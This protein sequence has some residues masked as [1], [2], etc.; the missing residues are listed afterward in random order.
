MGEEGRLGGGCGVLFFCWLGVFWPLS[1][2]S[3]CTAYRT[4]HLLSPMLPGRSPSKPIHMAS[5]CMCGVVP[6]AVR[7]GGLGLGAD[8]PAVGSFSQGT[9]TKKATWLPPTHDSLLHLP[10]ALPT[11]FPDLYS[12]V[13][14]C[15]VG[16]GWER[17]QGVWQCSSACAQRFVGVWVYGRAQTFS[18]FFSFSRGVFKKRMRWGYPP[19][20]YPRPPEVTLPPT[21][22]ATA[23]PLPLPTSHCLTVCVCSEETG[24]SVVV[25]FVP[26]ASPMCPLV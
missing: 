24:W 23:L 7:L 6:A 3:A 2:L 16:E 18:L 4:R 9:T 17:E 5:V 1:S 8:W 22:F 15:G 21:P 25:P 26:F 13:Q 14:A 11:P 12:L 10:S 19:L 20:L